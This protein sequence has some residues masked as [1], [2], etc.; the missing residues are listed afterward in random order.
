METLKLLH[1][2]GQLNSNKVGSVSCSGGEAALIADLGIEKGLQFPKLNKRQKKHLRLALGP[3]VALANP[4]DYHTYIWRDKNA[5]VNAWGAIIDP[6]LAITFFILDYPRSDRCDLADWEIATDVVIDVKEK[7]LSKIAVVSTLPEL[8]PEHVANRLMMN[9]IV[10]FNGLSEALTATRAGIKRSKRRQKPLLISLS[11]G[12]PKLVPEFEAKE[13]LN[14]LGINVPNGVICNSFSQ[15]PVATKK[16]KFPLVVKSI[17]TAHKTEKNGVHLNCLSNKDVTIAARKV[18]NSGSFLIEEM[19]PKGFEL[20]IGVVKSNDQ[21]FILTI[22]VGGV[23]SELSEDH[24]SV[25]VPSSKSDFMVALKQLNIFKILKGY[26]GLEG[27]D[28]ASIV[29]T[30]WKLQ[31]YVIKNFNN[32]IEIEV[33]PLICTKHGAFVADALIMEIT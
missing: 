6:I 31:T 9:G 12:K 17:N 5:M 20:L 27:A 26:R 23:F 16:L 33:N 4:L 11:K 32:L 2:H 10:P 3:K 13:R 18:T 15:I 1:C 19:V 21:G 28:L 8:M 22:G 24:V 25:L 14:Q 30:V 29:E 7:T